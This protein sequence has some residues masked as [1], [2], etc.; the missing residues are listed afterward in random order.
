MIVCA[1]VLALRRRE[2]NLHRPFKTPLVWFTAPAGMLF[3]LYLIYF[4][5]GRTHSKLARKS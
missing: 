5:Y 3:C 2:P 1:A 4:A